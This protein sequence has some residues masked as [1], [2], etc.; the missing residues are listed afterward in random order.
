M[1]RSRPTFGH[2]EPHSVRLSATPEHRTLHIAHEKL[3]HS[4]CRQA[5]WPSPTY[6]SDKCILERC[7]AGHAV[8]QARTSQAGSVC[9]L[10][11]RMPGGV[12]IRAAAER[13]VLCCSGRSPW[14]SSVTQRPAVD[15][16][17]LPRVRSQ[18]ICFFKGHP[19]L[20]WISLVHLKSE[21]NNKK[22]VKFF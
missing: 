7:S 5:A 9:D 2:Q 8:R 22:K 1:G 15:V 20:V 10:H 21:R 4:G 6:S 17:Y 3:V 13:E 18:V 12:L 16:K 19:F 11:S 14:S